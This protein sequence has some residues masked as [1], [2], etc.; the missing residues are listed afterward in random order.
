MGGI[1]PRAEKRWKKKEEE[2]R[3]CPLE[4][5]VQE[6]GAF[7]FRSEGNKN[8]AFP[9][10]KFDVRRDNLSTPSKKPHI[11]LGDGFEIGGGELPKKASSKTGISKSRRG[12]K[13]KKAGREGRACFQWEAFM[14]KLFVRGNGENGVHGPEKIL[15]RGKNYCPL[16]E[17]CENRGKGTPTKVEG[18][19][20]VN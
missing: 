14:G 16:G 9:G 18:K 3:T 13:K 1:A 2:R 17:S 5:Y 15:R 4:S 11:V 20:G 7:L 6:G 19:K 12:S 10:G 8:W